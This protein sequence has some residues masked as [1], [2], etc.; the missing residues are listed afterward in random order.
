MLAPDLDNVTAGPGG[1]VDACPG[2]MVPPVLES[3]LAVP[4]ALSSA[5][6]AGER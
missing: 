1:G 3:G 4:P 2:R 6:R 5:T